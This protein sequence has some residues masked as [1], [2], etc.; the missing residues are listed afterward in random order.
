M[1]QCGT[2]LMRT[3]GRSLKR[4]LA[5]TLIEASIASAIAAM[6]F[7]GIIYGYVMS[8]RSAEW[9]AYSFAAQARA[10]QRLEQSRACRWDPDAT[11]V[12][13]DLQ[14]TNFLIEVKVL[15]VPLNGTNITYATNIT[16][17]S[18]ISTVP[19]LRMISV[20]TTWQ[21]IDGKVYT[22]SIATYRAP[23]A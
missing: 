10:L 21:F 6:M 11:P 1:L 23:D 3:K 4:C 19:P 15:D 18:T 22:N 5:F 7:A 2:N 9:S 17:I 13:D 20:E 16:T 14:S 8:N 12:V